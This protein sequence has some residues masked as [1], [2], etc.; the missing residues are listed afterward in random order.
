VLDNSARDPAIGYGEN[1]EYA[2]HSAAETAIPFRISIDGA[3][4]AVAGTPAGVKPL[5]PGAEDKQRVEDLRLEAVD[6]QVKFDGLEVQPILNVSTKPI[7]RLVGQ[8]EQVAFFGSWNYP[9]WIVRREVRILNAE[10]KL[11]EAVLMSASGDA[12]WKTPASVL[13][14]VENGAFGESLSYTLRVY[15]AKGRFDETVPLPLKITQASEG[16]YT[17]RDGRGDGDAESAFASEVPGYGED[18]TA[19]R[20]IPVH[21][22]VVTVYGRHIPEG[23]TVSAFGREI[24]LGRDRDFVAQQIVEPGTE[25]IKVAVLDQSGEGLRFSRDILIPEN[26]WFYVGLADLAVGRTFDI[27]KRVEALDEDDRNRFYTRGRAAGYVKG[28]IQGKYLLTA[29]IDTGDALAAP[30][31]PG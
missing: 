20:N 18:R 29:A 13:D 7:E 6:I 14:R 15:D 8:A 4:V 5:P 9:D 27:S 16:I 31:R 19:V 30:A 3:P 1:T 17:D 25:T 2:P 12:A 22:G 21:G 23:H 26:D 10:G 24:P 28:K 11:V